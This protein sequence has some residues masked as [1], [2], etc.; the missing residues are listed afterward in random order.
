MK[1]TYIWPYTLRYGDPRHGTIGAYRYLGC[2]CEPC[3]DASA[4]DRRRLRKVNKTQ[5]D[6]SSR[7]HGNVTTYTN[8]GCR[9]PECTAAMTA[10]DPRKRHDV[11]RAAS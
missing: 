5:L 9:C 11:R 6:S 8:W 3:Q 1:T 4:L 2:R 7:P 10:A